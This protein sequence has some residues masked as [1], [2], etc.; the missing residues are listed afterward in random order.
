MI[1]VSLVEDD[2]DIRSTLS[3]LIDGADGFAC[4]SDY[5]DC[6]SALAAIAEDAPDVVLMDIR[7]P[8][9]SGIDG[10]AAVKRL[11]PDCDV[12]MLTVLPDDDLVFRALRAGATG[13]LVKGSGTEKILDAVR[14]VRSGGA[15]MSTTIA[16]KIVKS[17]RAAEESPLSPRETEVLGELC[18]GRSYRSI[19][20]T[21]HVSRDTV[22]FHIKNI[23][24]KLQVHSMSEAVAKALKDRLV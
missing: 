18:R 3:M 7:L 14:E 19:A 21:L 23:Y 2:D 12:V 20:E 22:H 13:Y 4:V 11:L 24:R 8:G 1:K 15:P 9:M 17:F 5:P 10:A 16:R 6:E